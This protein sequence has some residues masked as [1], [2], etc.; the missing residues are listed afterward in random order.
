MQFLQLEDFLL[1][2]VTKM[3]A[4]S[5]AIHNAGKCLKSHCSI[6]NWMRNRMGM[7]YQQIAERY[8]KELNMDLGDFEELCIEVDNWENEGGY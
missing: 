7:N 8:K 2:G 5:K 1:W 6:M 4:L 3:S